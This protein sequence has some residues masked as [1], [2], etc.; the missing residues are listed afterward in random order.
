MSNKRRN[1]LTIAIILNVAIVVVQIIFGFIANSIGLLADAGHNLVD[2]GA[3]ILSLFAIILI[4]RAPT[5]KRTF[6]FHRSGILAAQANA[7]SI[8][9]ITIF[10]SY[11]GIKR[12]ITPQEVNGSL[13][14]IVAGIGA[15]VNLG[16][17]FALK[18]SD[19]GHKHDMNIRS[20]TL[21]LVGD[22]LASLAVVIT[23]LVIIFTG[24]WYWLDPAISLT[25]GLFIA[26]HGRKSLKD[27]NN[28][29]LESTPKNI[30]SNKLVERI[31][32]LSGTK[33][34][35]DLHIWSISNE[36][37]ALSA[38]IVLEGEPTLQEAQIIGNRIK[39]ILK[40]DFGIAHATLEFESFECEDENCI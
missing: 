29:L 23:G 38:H 15:I 9:L 20:A 40:D 1:R 26:Y 11:E 19:G 31:L 28:V 17:A 5:Q 3:L 39:T 24:N 4:Q 16:S 2:V 10:I 13:I 36:I 14:V 35:H 7:I 25:I 33:Q 27:A 30:D 37:H 34:I 22:G 18:E 21:H 8:I 6:G 12:L 32:K